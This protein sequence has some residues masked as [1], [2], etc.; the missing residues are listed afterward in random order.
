MSPDPLD[1]MKVVRTTGF[2]GMCDS[3]FRNELA[4]Q[5]PAPRLRGGVGYIELRHLDE[6]DLAHFRQE[7]LAAGLLTLAPPAATS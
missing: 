3:T 7:L 4:V 2:C 1:G 6:P 5:Y